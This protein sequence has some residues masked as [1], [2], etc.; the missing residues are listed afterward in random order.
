VS[1]NGAGRTGS[2]S[3]NRPAKALGQA[4]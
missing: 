1:S 3:K 4:W 2:C